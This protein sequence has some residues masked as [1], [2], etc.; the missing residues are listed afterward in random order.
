MT[1]SD[2]PPK[3][4]TISVVIPTFRRRAL[5]PEV[6]APLLADEA[7]TELIVVVDGSRDG[8][9][10]YLDDLA[11]REPRLHPLAIENRGEN[12]ARQAG[13]ARATGE[14]V[15]FLDD[16][17][18]AGPGL[19]TGHL[20]HHAEAEASLVV[21]GYMPVRTH[22]DRPL[23]VAETLYAGWYEAQCAAWE[24]ASGSVLQ[25]LWAGNVS[26]R[27]ADAL[28]LGLAN[29]AYDA[30]YNPDRDLG[31]RLLEAGLHGRFDRTLR[32]E[33]LFERPLA[34]FLSDAY[35]TGEG[36]WL[37]HRLHGAHLG[38]L[39]RDTFE[40]GLRPYAQR[41]VRLTRRQRLARLA[42]L[43]ARVS[44]LAR[45]LGRSRAERAL[46]AMSFRALSQ[47]GALD[48]ARA[49]R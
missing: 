17:V 8:S 18:V 39:P 48:R 29:P 32:A 6:L 49:A 38:V 26:M 24:C 21:L 12:G 47:R 27:T 25:N 5:L 19:V 23:G 9:I 35:S 11:H 14:V 45:L 44:H 43:P 41:F 10:E 42:R 15:L 13:L 2:A 30:R 37:N 31:L 3:R 1:S 33:H 7:T 16:D 4:L 40:R 22:P 36:T 34:S 28:E 46:V 20:R